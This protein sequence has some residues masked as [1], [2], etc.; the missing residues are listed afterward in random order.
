MK[1]GMICV[2]CVDDTIFA[3][4]NS[5]DLDR[6]IVALSNSTDEH[7]HTFQLRNKDVVGWCFSWFSNG[8]SGTNKLLLT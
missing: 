8:K 7:C 5:A 3:T 2:V 4:T 6:E 1:P